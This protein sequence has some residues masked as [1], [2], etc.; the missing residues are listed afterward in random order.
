VVLGDEEGD[1]YHV[2][3][4][5]DDHSVGEERYVTFGSRPNDPRVVLRISWT[6]RST[7]KRQVTRI[8][9]A[10][11]ATNHERKRYVEEIRDQ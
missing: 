11:R 7:T 3:Q 5:D 9:S 1:V 2:E 6:D 10:R 4:A 8:I